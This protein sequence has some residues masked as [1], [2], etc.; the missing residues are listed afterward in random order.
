MTRDKNGILAG[1][2]VRHG[3][4]HPKEYQYQKSYIPLEKYVDY[5]REFIVDAATDAN[6]TEDLMKSRMSKVVLASDDPEVYASVDMS[7]ALRAQELILMASKAAIDKAQGGKKANKFVEDNL[8][9][10][11][12]FYADVFWAL[13]D[14]S[15][16]T[17]A[18]ALRKRQDMIELEVRDAPSE[19]A[20]QLRSLV[21]RAYVMDLAV[22][23]RTDRVVCGVSSVACR[24][25]AVMMGWKEAIVRGHWKNIDG[26]F[27][28]S[29]IE[30]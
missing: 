4:R 13:G 15:K 16:D 20:M 25:L 26:D 28:W 1:I 30:W 23:G 6:G 14:E 8:G 5:A 11:G 24:L 27:D 10:E 22:L 19:T 29:G 12:G 21:G 18:R 17:S 7:H 2:H 3:D 9:W